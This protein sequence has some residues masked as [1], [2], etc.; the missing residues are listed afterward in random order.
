[1]SLIFA[2]AA[3]ATAP[4]L[5]TEHAAGYDLYA[6]ED[7]VVTGG[8]GF[9][10]VNCGVHVEIPN[11]MYGRIAPR[12]GLAAKHHL[13]TGAGV[14]DCDYR[15]TIIVLLACTKNNYQYTVTRGER[16]AQLVIEYC[17][18]LTA[19]IGVPSDTVRGSSGF[20]STG[21]H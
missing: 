18:R 16:I 11:G 3:G 20:G 17:P 2:L 13:T 6:N 7:K 15:G 10:A 21:T 14:I 19:V 9:V 1:M 4:T 5:A 12:S 8:D